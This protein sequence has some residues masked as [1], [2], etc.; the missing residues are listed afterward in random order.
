MKTIR[1]EHYKK[2]MR[3]RECWNCGIK[4]KKGERYL[5]RELRYDLKIITISFCL[6]DTCSPKLVTEGGGE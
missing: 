2:A 4:I 1:S 3:D 5:N 6:S